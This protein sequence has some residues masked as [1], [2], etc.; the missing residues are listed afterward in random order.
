MSL[1]NKLF[2][3]I[4]AVSAF[5]VAGSAQE[6]K[7]LKKDGD[8][9]IERRG[10][11]G[12]VFAKGT[13]GKGARGFGFR[14]IDLSDAQ[15]AQM[16]A[17][18]EANKPDAALREEMKTLSAA[19]RAGTATGQ[20]LLRMQTIRNEGKAKRDAIHAQIEAILTPEQKAQIETRKQEMKTRREE[21]RQRFQERRQQRPTDKPV[22]TRIN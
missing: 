17:I 2:A 7:E 10:H 21:M 1:K 13:H 9:K 11:R 5:A 3:G 20:Q 8:Q 22:D 6:T 19:R 15:K 14:G 12:E 16:K 4:F 18:H